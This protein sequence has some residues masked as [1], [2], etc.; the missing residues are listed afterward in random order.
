[1]TLHLSDELLSARLDG[2]LDA[3]EAAEMQAHLA[4]C[5]TCR[6]RMELM[7]AT[8][9]AVAALPD[10]ATPA[11]LDLSFLDRR[12][13]DARILR[14]SPARW[15]PP[16]WAVPATAAA[17]VLLVAVSFGPSLLAGHGGAGTSAGLGASQAGNNADQAPQ[18]ATR[19]AASPVPGGAGG[20]AALNTQ[21]GPAGSG[22]RSLNDSQG[23]TLTLTP[24]S[25]TARTGQPLRLAL[26]VRA[27]RAVS[28]GSVSIQVRG[29]GG[30]AILA[31]TSSENLGA[32]Q[33]TT[34]SV[35]W[36]AG[37]VSGPAQPGDYQVEGHVIL[38]DGRDEFVAV[39]VHAA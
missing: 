31:S 4:E 39:T 30:S 11:A 18:F 15:R 35:N 14:P 13:G 32:G 5:E 23:L 6:H 16:V 34:L 29:G 21:A 36:S 10:E 3:S 27:S 28:L 22:T 2:A 20:G 26:E 7:Q 1:V 17:A 25:T 9:Q 33:N 12:T 24:A 19:S 37:Q 38:A 8:K